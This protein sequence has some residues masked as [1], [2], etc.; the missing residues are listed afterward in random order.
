MSNVKID[1]NN[2]IGKMKIMHAV[3]NGPSVSASD[4]TRG[5]QNAYQACR[6]PYARTHDASFYS[7]Y[8]GNHTVDVNFIFTDFEADVN[9]PKSY[10]FACTDRYM[11]QIITYGAKPYFRLGSRIEHEVKKY[12]TYPPRN[13]QKWAEI[14][15]HIIA[16]YT[17]GW[18]NGFKYDMKYWEIW[19][20]PDLDLNEE[21]NK[22]LWQG[23]EEEFYE[24]FIT[25][26]KHLKGR[27]PNLKIG[28]PA[29]AGDETWMARFLPKI[30]KADTPL[31][32]F[33]YHWYWTQPRDMTNKCT[34]VRKLLDKN[35]YEKTEAHLNEWNYVRGWDKDFVY[36]IK[37]IIGAKGAAFNM[38]CMSAAQNCTDVDM[39]M[40]YDARPSEWNG[41]FDFY[42]LEPIKGYY[43]F[44]TFAN[45]YEMGSQV[46][47]ESN[48]ESV[49][50]LAARGEKRRGA[51][52]TYYTEN[53]SDLA[54]DVELEL[55][56][57]DPK[58]LKLYLVD[59]N[60]TY[61]ENNRYQIN[62]NKIKMHLLRNSFVYMED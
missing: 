30:K 32:F 40:Y 7:V 61:T 17:E 8:G 16:H 47:A 1:F 36:S 58:S 19:A 38:A 14:C 12:N 21:Y 3:N 49:Y 22:R 37:Q 45:L 39:L 24:L 41:L 56:G 59:E 46:K 48:D 34:R 50:V 35:G 18:A 43:S 51:V 57:V 13:F 42:T 5:N 9:D 15:E 4:Q 27:F 10:D 44:Y 53:D 11:E 28:G 20:E 6:I 31:D 62:G 23:T 55:E 52:I 2:E 26:A 33:S 29:S 60:N 25:A 54:K